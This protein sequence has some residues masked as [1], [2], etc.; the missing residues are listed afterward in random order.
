MQ[1]LLKQKGNE[2]HERVAPVNFRSEQDAESAE[3]NSQEGSIIIKE[4][5]GTFY[6]RY[7]IIFAKAGDV[8]FMPRV[9]PKDFSL[10]TDRV[11]PFAASA[12]DFEKFYNENFLPVKKEEIKRFAKL[13]ASLQ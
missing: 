4:G 5:E 7:N 6:V 8:F 9:V 13:S 1:S 11:I 10:D 3:N 12:G 2:A